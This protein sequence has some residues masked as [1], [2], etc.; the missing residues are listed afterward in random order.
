M[1]SNRKFREPKSA[2]EESEILENAVSRSNRS[3]NK[4]AMKILRSGRREEQIR[5]PVRKK[6]GLLWKLLKSKVWK[7]TFAT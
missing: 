6:E 2:V 5:R 3:V 7:R 4:G 1:A